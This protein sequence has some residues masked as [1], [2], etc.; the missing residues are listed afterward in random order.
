MDEIPHSSEKKIQE[1]KNNC[2]DKKKNL[3]DY[4][5]CKCCKCFFK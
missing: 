4:L 5:I 3:K 2:V 1:K